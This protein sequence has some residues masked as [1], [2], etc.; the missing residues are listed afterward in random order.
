M[1]KRLIHLTKSLGVLGA[2]QKWKSWSIIVIQ[3]GSGESRTSADDAEPESKPRRG[4]TV[5][6]RAGIRT[7]RLLSVYLN[8]VSI[9]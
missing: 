8:D 3:A 1:M 4:F 9:S 7:G 5:K 6:S 2:K